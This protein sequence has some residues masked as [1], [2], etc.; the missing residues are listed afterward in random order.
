[1]NILNSFT[2]CNNFRRQLDTTAP[3]VPGWNLLGSTINFA[4]DVKINSAGDRIAISGST[5]IKVYSWNGSNWTQLG[6]D[7]PF[8]NNTGYWVPFVFNSV[9]DTIAASSRSAATVNG[10]Q[11][12]N[13]SVFAVF[14][15][16]G[17]SWAIKGSP[18]VGAS[19]TT[20]FGEGIAM[21][22]AGTRVFIADHYDNTTGF[23]ANGKVTPYEWNG[24]TWVVKTAI[25]G[26]A[27]YEQ[28]GMSIDCSDDGTHVAIGSYSNKIRK[29][30][31]NGT[32]WT[33]IGA[34]ITGDFSS[35]FIGS[36]SIAI[37][38]N[39]TLISFNQDQ[40]TPGYTRTYFYNGSTW[41]KRGTDISGIISGLSNNTDGTYIAFGLSTNTKVYNW[42]GSSWVQYGSNIPSA[43]GTIINTALNSD[44]SRV[45]LADFT[46]S[47][48]RVYYY[49]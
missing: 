8:F 22:S 41:T 17:S 20:F 25:A 45:V 49:V 33:K 39:G 14:T 15:W 38:S 34:D 24:S 30:T 31:Y 46:N 43:G 9:G 42:N 19:I 44:A 29:Y 5:G 28:I 4:G 48:V 27:N 10:T 18:T 40:N 7:I 35:D 13:G 32:T 26:L 2:N 23:T 11:Y 21:N 1:M 3:I 16:N 12:A 37:N 6:S 47:I 36:A